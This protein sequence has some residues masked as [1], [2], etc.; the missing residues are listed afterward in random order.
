MKTDIGKMLDIMSE[1]TDT[2]PSKQSITEKQIETIEQHLTEKL[3]SMVSS[4]INN[5]TVS[6]AGATPAPDTTDTASTTD[7]A[8]ETDTTDTTTIND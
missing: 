4:A 6:N 3:D 1:S 8:P 7:T 5:N 2:A